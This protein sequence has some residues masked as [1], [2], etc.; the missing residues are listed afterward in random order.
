MNNT[1]LNYPKR[2]SYMS[3]GDRDT[4][5]NMSQSEPGM[6]AIQRQPRKNTACS[7][8]R[9]NTIRRHSR[10]HTV[11][12][13]ARIGPAHS[14]FRINR[15]LSVAAA[16]VMLCVLF[17]AWMVP[18]AQAQDVIRATG[19]TNLSIDNVN[20]DFTTLSGPT[21]R[22]TSVGE[23]EAGRTI[24]LTLPDS[25][26]GG[27]YEWN[28][29]LSVMPQ[30]DQGADTSGYDVKFVI[31][32]RGAQNTDL[33]L[34]FT[35]LTGRTFTFT[36]TDESQAAGAGK[37]PGRIMIYGLELR[38][39]NRNVPDEATIT[40]TGTTGPDVNYGNL[41]KV[42]G[43]IAEVR[44][45][46]ESDGT[47]EVFPDSTILA[48]NSITAYAIARDEG[49]N[50]IEN[51]ALNEE[52]D[53]SL[54][55]LSGGITQSALTAGANLR[56]A[57][58]STTTSGTAV[59]E[60][61]Y[62]DVDLVP[63][64]TITVAPRSASEMVIDTQPPDTVVAGEP[65][66][67]QPVI[68]LRDQ[69]G[70][71]VTTDSS[72]VVD[73]SI[74]TGSGDLPGTTTET[75][76]GGV[77]AFT[78]LYAQVAGE[79]TLEFE[80][81]GL[82]SITSDPVVV[83]PN[84]PEKLTFL[85]Q[86]TNTAIGG[87]IN[88]P[89]ELQL[90]DDFDNNVPQSGIDVYISDEAYFEADSS[91][92]VATNAE[93]IAVFSDL[94]IDDDASEDSQN[95]SVSFFDL[96]TVDPDTVF[97]M[98]SNT[99][100]ILS[101]GELASFAII[102]PAEEPIGDQEAGDEFGIRIEARTAGGDVYT[103]F[104]SHVFVTA[105][106]DIE[107]D[108]AAVDTFQTATFSDGV[109]DTTITLTS[110]G[111][112][113]IYADIDDFNGQ[114]YSGQSNE[115]EVLPGP[116]DFD[117]TLVSA[118]PAE[119]IADGQSTT[120]VT[121][122][123]RDAY[124]NAL[125]D[126]MEAGDGTISLQT[127]AGL[128]STS[129]ESET[130]SLQAED[131]SDGTYTA[132]L[133]ASESVDTVTVTA[134][135]VPDSDPPVNIGDVEVVFMPGDVAEFVI[136]IP[137]ENGNGSPAEQTAG[138]KFD[139]T[140]EALDESGNLAVG[141]DGTLNFTSNSDISDGGTAS[142]TNGILEN[143]EITLTKSGTDITLTAEDPDLY[144]VSGTSPAF[145]VVASDPDVA[146]S[147]VTVNPNVIQ[148]D[149]ESQSVITV[150]LRDEYSNKVLRDLSGNLS[151]DLERVDSDDP[152]NAS[153]TGVL[154]FMPGTSTY[155]DT[156]TSTSTLEEVKVLVSYDPPEV[157]VVQLTETPTIDIV[158]PNVWEPTGSPQ[159]RDDWTRAENWSL[160]NV[161]VE[162]DFVIFPGGL[163]DYPVVDVNPSVGSLEIQA[164]GQLEVDFDSDITVSGAVQV[165][166]TLDI[167]V[168]TEIFVGGNL[169]GTGSFAASENATLEIGGN[170]SIENFL[171][172]TDGTV[173]KFNGETQQEL[174][175]TNLLA[176]RLE[177]QNDVLATSGDV[178]DTSELLITEGNTFE[179]E[180]QSEPPD[181][182]SRI[183]VDNIT[184][185]FGQGTFILNNNRLV[186]RGD[187]SLVNIDTSEGT[188]IFG[189]RPGEEFD[190]FD[191]QQQQIENLSAMKNATVNNIE[192]VRTFKDIKI[193]GSLKLLCGP[194]I[195]SSGKSL[196]APDITYGGDSPD[197]ND[198]GAGEFGYLKFR[199]MISANPGWRMMSTPVDTATYK[200]LFDGLTIQGIEGSDFPDNPEGDRYQ[201]NLFWYN[202]AES[203]GTAGT[204]DLQRW[205]TP[206]SV[207]EEMTPGRGYFFFVFDDRDDDVGN[208]LPYT[209]TASGQENQG[210]PFDFGV[211]YT[212]TTESSDPDSLVV[213]A[214]TGWN[215]IGNPFGATIDWEDAVNENQW[216]KTNVDD[217]IYL[218]QTEDP[219]GG[220]I[221]GEYKV[222][223]GITG[224]DFESL[225]NGRI[226]PFQA[227]WVKANDDNPG[228]T[229]EPG[230]KTT[231][232]QFLQKSRAGSENH[233]LVLN[234][235]AGGLETSAFFSFTEDGK[236]GL[237]R[238]DGYLLEPMADTYLN[239]YSVAL[240]DR[241]DTQIPL[242]INNLPKRSE[243]EYEIPLGVRGYKQGEPIRGTYNVELSSRTSIPEHWDVRLKDNVT[244]ETIE[245][246]NP[247]ARRGSASVSH[248]RQIDYFPGLREHVEVPSMQDIMKESSPVASIHP[249][250][251]SRQD[252][253]EGSSES[254][255]S[256]NTGSNDK[257]PENS[258]SV[259]GYADKE[260]P[261]TL[262]ITPDEL[263]DGDVPNRFYLN[264]NYPNPFNPN[265]TIEFGLPDDSD[266]RIVVYDILGRRVQTLAN[267]RFDAGVHSVTFDGTRYASG[268]YIYRLQTSEQAITRKK[269]LIK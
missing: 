119:I 6:N 75:A 253:V 114:S 254:T 54:T 190:E 130:D 247:V 68:H 28:D 62:P 42:A 32:P 206:G 261:F 52:S 230:A 224:G 33:A 138:T 90:L 27:G 269:T 92:A 131:M 69:F 11:Q 104:E 232:G 195:I 201:P 43:S 262:F 171:A 127:T 56:S 30:A 175:T 207:E 48:G 152:P 22:E 166:G 129:T 124:G 116:V 121:V 189:I 73:V 218:W 118:D 94:K 120:L 20:G 5:D 63:S 61:D 191:L 102:T 188:V 84:V 180:Q 177:I 47:G 214:E 160:G 172:G 111:T 39:A 221:S 2:Q 259:T 113:R 108:G 210:S 236:I 25:P 249:V 248:S 9:M 123:L 246:N 117:S 243:S 227:F 101:A 66:D 10:R 87:T 252:G 64:G 88:P 60:A 57:T 71:L 31:E 208:E 159:Q 213:H 182:D 268:V 228:L 4:R 49:G 35:E 170:V 167:R 128:L 168:N 263:E 150:T 72:T 29:N 97:T 80:S 153:V 185:I 223:N 126:G 146:E 36:I 145:T 220:D 250:H 238:R 3:K 165:D 151:L 100:Q 155:Q 235:K 122:S 211:T 112:T 134:F 7:G 135:H 109:L 40:N 237:D 257:G 85:Q 233:Q 169:S 267:E 164:G 244:G 17:G 215:L 93:G 55:G 136:S 209:L 144:G 142:V 245:L 158:L 81:G 194:L 197:Y 148:N 46:T 216:T 24:V 21:I 37:G 105:D 65:F 141:Y 74:G 176:Q 67:P 77:V 133:T 79:I 78:N 19:V 162:T 204:T 265:T 140:V 241:D 199:R 217:V 8:S 98:V 53:W 203:E 103:G 181:V 264:Q 44:V 45:E 251:E 91:Q 38:P 1:V 200:G 198:C 95:F 107:M 234:L 154:T 156:L 186:V 242:V 26:D 173:V 58:F 132:T 139:I 256:E 225:D 179:M 110:T 83:E 115:F 51:A 34:E 96:V 147:R 163:D 14:E 222:W 15:A 178:I 143:H 202:E 258:G 192:G 59:I 183:T 231:G 82:S 13:G 70:N 89:V 99:F 174:S 260:F 184:D 106:A 23:L 205:Q 157:N 219:G 229:V 12:K 193:D 240:I 266:V 86:P 137:M 212:D 50:F 41:S 226:P 196:D 187:L 16:M 125:A 149:G 18:H 239:F 255:G 76:V 161:P